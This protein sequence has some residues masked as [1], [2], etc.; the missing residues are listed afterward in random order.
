MFLMGRGLSQT[1]RV[2]GVVSHPVEVELTRLEAL[3]TLVM[4]FDYYRV[5]A[6]LIYTKVKIKDSTLASPKKGKS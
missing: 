1:F 5:K 2:S 4:V 6:M 3:L